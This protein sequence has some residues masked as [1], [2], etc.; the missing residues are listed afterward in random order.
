MVSQRRIRAVSRSHAASFSARFPVLR[1]VSMQYRW[2]ERLCL[3]RN[4]VAAFGEVMPGLYSACCQNG[5]GTAKGTLHG[6]LAAELASGH[7]SALLQQVQKQ[8]PPSPTAA[9]DFG[10]A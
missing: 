7:D 8:S 2:G 1:H 9:A 4:N 3:S 6:M 5:L 10:L